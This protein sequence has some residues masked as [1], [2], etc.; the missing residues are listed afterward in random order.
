MKTL[1]IICFA[2]VFGLGWVGGYN[3]RPLEYDT[4][5]SDSKTMSTHE[6]KL[7]IDD[8]IRSHQYYIDHPESQSFATGNTTFN[9]DIVNQYNRLKSL[10]DRLANGGR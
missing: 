4:R 8:A 1:T 3:L 9:E 10:T 6:A 2:L 5:I 7:F